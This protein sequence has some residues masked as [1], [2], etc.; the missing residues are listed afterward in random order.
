MSHWSWPSLRMAY[1]RV[2]SDSLVTKVIYR[3]E[4]LVV[5]HI[6]GKY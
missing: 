3:I 5:H 6:I 1:L 2:S 4:V